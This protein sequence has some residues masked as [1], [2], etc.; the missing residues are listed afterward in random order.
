MVRSLFLLSLVLVSFATGFLP[1]SPLPPRCHIRTTATATSTDTMMYTCAES[2]QREYSGKTVL[3]TGASGGLGRAL[4]L[5][6]SSC[7][8]K[9]LVLSARN[10]ESLQ[11][12]SDAC[13]VVNEAIQTTLLT[14]DL[15]DPESVSKL[16]EKASQLDIQVLVN[17]GGVSSRSSFISTSIDVDARMMQINFLSGA[18]LAKAVIPTMERG[19]RL[20]WIS[21]VQ[22]LVGIPSRSSYAA[23]KFAVQGYCESIRGELALQGVSVHTISP[24]YICTNLSKSAL[25]GDGTP[26]GKMDPTTAAGADPDQVAVTILD[27]TA[28]GQADFV[29]AA[30]LSAKAAIW[31]RF[32]CP[33]LLRLL[34]VKRYEKQVQKQKD[35]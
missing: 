32:L 10:L 34:L 6:L 28:A 25:N 15:S 33:A 5:Q 21:S 14:C 31:L 11:E 13:K 18:A 12:V 22:G 23:S 1:A 20:V 30:T 16:S 24:G 2:T 29:V 19:G 9:H 7:K 17:N 8:V 26:Y 3:L 35:D 4:A 27:K